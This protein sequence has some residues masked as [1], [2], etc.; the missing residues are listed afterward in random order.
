MSMIKYFMT[1]LIGL[2]LSTAAHAETVFYCE[3]ANFV[4]VEDGVE[5]YRNEKFKIKVTSDKV[6]FSGDGY[7]GSTE[8][9]FSEYVNDDSWIAVGEFGITSLKEGQHFLH[10]YIGFGANLVI[11]IKG[12]CSK[13]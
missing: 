10:A 2:A 13:F 6:R 5:E 7:F 11:A 4:V 9:D 12:E 8:I 1:S 3:S